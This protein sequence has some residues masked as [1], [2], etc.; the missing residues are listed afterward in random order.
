VLIDNVKELF[1]LCASAISIVVG[2]W[3]SVF[4]YKNWKRSHSQDAP[5]A[6]L[7]K[8]IPGIDGL[9]ESDVVIKNNSIK[10]I[11]IY[12]IELEC[13][14]FSENCIQDCYGSCIGYRRGY[15]KQKII[16]ILV[17]SRQDKKIFARFHIEKECAAIDV[18]LVNRK[19]V[20]TALLRPIG[21]PG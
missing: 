13:G 9:I 6:Y 5:C 1:V 18:K 3:A 7:E 19:G 17:P 10:S 4:I 2:I 8:F 12:S 16:S 14:T 21:A 20:F 11:L 15:Q